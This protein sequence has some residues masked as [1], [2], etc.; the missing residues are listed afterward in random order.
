MVLNAPRRHRSS[1]TQLYMGGITCFVH[2]RVYWL[3]RL[4][5]PLCMV[6]PQF[7]IVQP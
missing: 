4:H 7:R 1:R 3:Q 6:H 5:W 2:H